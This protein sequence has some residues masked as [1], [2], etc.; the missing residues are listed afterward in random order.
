MNATFLF[1]RVLVGKI[2]YLFK[3]LKEDLNTRARYKKNDL[4]DLLPMILKTVQKR[5]FSHRRLT[6][7][8]NFVTRRKNAIKSSVMKVCL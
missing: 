1:F 8:K 2:D 4:S 7:L 3:K 5:W 6:D